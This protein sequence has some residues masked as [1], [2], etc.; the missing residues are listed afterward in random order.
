MEEISV[1][2]PT[3]AYSRLTGP[4]S[5]SH[6][7][8][9]PPGSLVRVPLGARDSLGL[10]WPSASPDAANPAPPERVL[11]PIAQVLD[12]SLELTSLDARLVQPYYAMQLARSAGLM[13]G[14]GMDGA[15]VLVRAA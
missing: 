4:L 11:K 1:L 5:Y 2:L 3:P 15:D 13:L 7:S 12:G 8:A 6:P 9:L 10:V 14:M